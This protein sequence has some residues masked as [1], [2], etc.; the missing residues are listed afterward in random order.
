MVSLLLRLMQQWPP[1]GPTH[2]THPSLVV[3]CTLK[4]GSR[5]GQDREGAEWQRVKGRL[6]HIVWLVMGVIF[7]LSW[8]VGV[9]L[10]GA[11]ISA[12][13]VV[14]WVR[15]AVPLAAPCPL[16]EECSDM[17][18]NAA[19]ANVAAAVPCT[20]A[21]QT[22]SE[23]MQLRVVCQPRVLS[24]VSGASTRPVTRTHGHLQLA[25]A[26]LLCTALPVGS[27]GVLHVQDAAS[28]SR[29]LVQAAVCSN[30]LLLLCCCAAE[31]CCTSLTTGTASCCQLR[32]AG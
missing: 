25:G 29:P 8:L 10:Y 16:A 11:H 7:A 14:L 1:F 26:A 2:S 18:G 30:A 22:S 9:M 23:C 24:P 32:L 12:V 31:L 13:C 27:A 15:T 19:A 3:E 28:T 4:V 5:L 21:I 17:A 20:N 6:R